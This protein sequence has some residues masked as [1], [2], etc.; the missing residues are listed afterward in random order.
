MVGYLDFCVFYHLYNITYT[1]AFYICFIIHSTDILTESQ[2][3]GQL[4]YQGEYWTGLLSVVS[5][6]IFVSTDER[7]FSLE[8]IA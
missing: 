3:K 6:N 4:L 1:K 2:V 8:I 7:E 5:E